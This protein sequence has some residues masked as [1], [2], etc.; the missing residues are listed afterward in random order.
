MR[1]D[2][3]AVREITNGV[4]F[5]MTVSL[6]VF[7]VLFLVRIFRESRFSMRDVLF[8][9]TDN[10]VIDA[11]QI[12]LALLF[13]L[14]GTMTRAGWIWVDLAQQNFGTD[15][16]LQDKPWIIVVGLMFGIAGAACLLRVMTRRRFGHTLWAWIVAWSVAV[17]ILVY[18]I[19]DSF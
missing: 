9:D 18:Y 13:F 3:I 7:S 1:L 8:R 12:V 2:E 15:R 11:I 4:W 17:P 5:F 19:G 16:W 10:V 6:V 14:V